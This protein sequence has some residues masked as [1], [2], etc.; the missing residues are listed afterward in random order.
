VDVTSGYVVDGDVTRLTQVV[1]NLLTNAGKY[2]DAEGTIAVRCLREDDVGVLEISDNGIGIEATLLP[3]IFELFTQE[4][5]SVARSRGGL[6]L[7]LAIARTLVQLHGGT[8]TVHSD[9]RGRG[10]TVRMRLPLVA[11]TSPGVDLPRTL[12]P[13][14]AARRRVLVVDDNQDA[15]EM[16]SA[17]AEHRGHTTRRAS[18]ATSALALLDDFSPD[19]ALLDLGLPMIDGFEL[20]RRIREIPRHRAI[21]LVAVTGYGQASDRQRTAAAGFDGHLVKPVQLDEV[22]QAIEA[23]E[24]P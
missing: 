21:R 8:L 17:L 10:T 2:T 11:T 23:A 15:A 12:T 13:P 19:V 7:G 24:R 14:E 20:A 4:P 3:R 18:D 1:T 6:G 22:L 5:Q 9:G 16:L